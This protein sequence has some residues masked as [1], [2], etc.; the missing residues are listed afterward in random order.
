MTV[1]ERILQDHPDSE[2][3]RMSE[4][5]FDAAIIGVD[6]DGERLIYDSNSVVQVLINDGMDDE[7]AWEYFYYNI[8]GAYVG[9]NTPLFIRLYV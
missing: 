1:L 2:L 9:K 6:Q 5:N 8:A 3:L 4:G 7:D